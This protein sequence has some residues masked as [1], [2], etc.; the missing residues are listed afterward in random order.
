MDL[1]SVYPYHLAIPQS[2]RR[3]PAGELDGHGHLQSA[4]SRSHAPAMVGTIDLH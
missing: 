2:P 3:S 1:F 4:H